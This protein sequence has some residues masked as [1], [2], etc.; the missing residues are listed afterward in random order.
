M[1]PIILR[2]CNHG[3]RTGGRTL[4][5]SPFSVISVE[6]GAEQ[7]PAG[8]LIA[9]AESLGCEFFLDTEN[10]L[11]AMDLDLRPRE[12][13]SVP[14]L[15]VIRS[16]R[17]R[18]RATAEPAVVAF[19]HPLKEAINPDVIWLSPGLD[20]VIFAFGGRDAG[21]LGSFLR[22]RPKLRFLEIGSTAVFGLEG[23][24][25]SL[26]LLLVESFSEEQVLFDAVI[27]AQ[28]AGKH[29]MNALN[30]IHRQYFTSCDPKEL[31]SVKKQVI[32]E[33]RGSGQLEGIGD[34]ERLA[35]FY[36]RDLELIWR[37]GTPCQPL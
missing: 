34:L 29:F 28:R 6:L 11:I 21:T 33:L 30:A 5:R 13:V 31:E 7:P 19:E 36:Q 17:D 10:R 35:K 24:D 32:G 14:S 18:I 23:G 27:S 25:R 37:L 3:V 22:G 9:G 26:Q 16:L 15:A 20:I 4:F 8:G 12:V 1:E 2:E